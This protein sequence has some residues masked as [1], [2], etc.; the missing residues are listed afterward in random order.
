VGGDGAA[1]AG[2]YLRHKDR[3][4]SHVLNRVRSTADAEDLTAETFELAWQKR[5][6]ITLHPDADILPWLFATANHLLQVHFHRAT[7][8]RTLMG[9]LLQSRVE[10]EADFSAQLA[11]QAEQDQTSQYLRAALETLRDTDREI[12]DLRYMENLS[13]TAIAEAM[14]VAAGAV[15]TRLSRAVSRA[16]HAYLIASA[17]ADSQ[18]SDPAVPND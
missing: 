10:P 13:P 14:G 7:R 17:D 3:L 5:A 16:Y 8:R 9:V 12:L 1:F 15:R 11:D 2:F 18:L 4:Y 6:A